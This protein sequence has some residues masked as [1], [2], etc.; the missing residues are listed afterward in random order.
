MYQ[1]YQTIF[2]ST[3]KNLRGTREQKRYDIYLDKANVLGVD[4]EALSAT[5]DVVLPYKA[6]DISTDT[7]K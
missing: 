6:M 7:A 3:K 2:Y 1:K 5:H 4:S